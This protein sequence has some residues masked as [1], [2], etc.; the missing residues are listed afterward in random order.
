MKREDMISPS[1]LMIPIT[2]RFSGNLLCL[3]FGT[4]FGPLSKHLSSFCLPFAC[5]LSFFFPSKKNQSILASWFLACSARA[6]LG[7]SD[8]LFRHE[9]ISSLQIRLVPDV[10]IKNSSDGALWNLEI[11]SN[12]SDSLSGV[13]INYFLHISI[14]VRCSDGIRTL[15]MDFTFNCCY[16]TPVSSFQ[17][18]LITKDRAIFR[19]R[20]D[21]Y[22]YALHYYAKIRAWLFWCLILFL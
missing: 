9:M 18:I 11:P 20:A 5:D 12:G 13:L 14:K 15:S 6:S 22:K 1:L 8:S 16:W 4:A 17:L 19:K 3:A 10:L 21:P 7:S 2:I